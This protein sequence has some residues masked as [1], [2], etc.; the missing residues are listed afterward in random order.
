MSDRREY[1]MTEQDH[2]AILDASKPVPL[3]YLS[4]GTPM[5]GTSQEN[6]NRAWESLGEKMGFKWRTAKPVDGKPRSFTAEP[7]GSQEGEE[8]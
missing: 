5:G 4:G 3:M 8:G 7:T 2:E 1:E 6:A